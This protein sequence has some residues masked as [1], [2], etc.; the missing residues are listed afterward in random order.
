MTLLGA[1]AQTGNLP[2]LKLLI[3]FHNNKNAPLNSI[4]NRNKPQYLQ[5]DS[6]RCK[7]IG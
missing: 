1:A 3:D 4:E 2:L 5:L 7:N 6:S